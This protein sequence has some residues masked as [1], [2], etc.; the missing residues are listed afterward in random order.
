MRYRYTLMAYR[1]FERQF[2]DGRLRAAR[3]RKYCDPSCSRSCGTPVNAKAPNSV[4]GTRFGAWFFLSGRP[5]LNRGPSAPKVYCP[6]KY[7]KYFPVTALHIRAISG[8]ISL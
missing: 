8:T 3:E 1:D 5:D 6:Y 2:T 7:F 4:L